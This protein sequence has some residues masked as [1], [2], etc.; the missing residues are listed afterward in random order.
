MVRLLGKEPRINRDNMYAIQL[1]LI[2]NDIV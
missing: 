1:L 2:I